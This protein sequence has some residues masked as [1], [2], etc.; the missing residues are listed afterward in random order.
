MKPE[1]RPVG[2]APAGS[3]RYINLQQRSQHAHLNCMVCACALSAH[4]MSSSSCYEGL[5]SAYGRLP[6][7][8]PAIERLR[9]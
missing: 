7:A 6:G 8:P 3:V 9:R 2:H 1:A 5:T 4:N